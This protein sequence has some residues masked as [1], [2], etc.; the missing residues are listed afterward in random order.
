MVF[1]GNGS[2][3]S[4]SSSNHNNRRSRVVGVLLLVVRQCAEVS[5]VCA[6][7]AG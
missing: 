4:S 3:S 5:R 7:S 2:L 6:S 1:T